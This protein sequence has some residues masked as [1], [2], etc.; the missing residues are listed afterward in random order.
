MPAVNTWA[1]CH[2]PGNCIGS[3]RMT[4]QTLGSRTAGADGAEKIYQ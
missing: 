2:V 3:R 1:F 4:A